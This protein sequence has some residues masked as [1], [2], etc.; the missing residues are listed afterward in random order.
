MSGLV[1]GFK[2]NSP[3]EEKVLIT[4]STGE[5]IILTY[6][7]LHNATVRIKIDAPKSINIKRVAL[8]GTKL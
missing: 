6:A 2:R 1:L 4:T 7:G 8:D 5:L 3:H